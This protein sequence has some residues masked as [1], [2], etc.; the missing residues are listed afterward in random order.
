MTR[1]CSIEYDER[2]FWHVNIWDAADWSEVP[3]GTPV[4]AFATTQ[5]GA[6]V[7]DAIALARRKFSPS[8]ICVWDTCVECSGEGEDADGSPCC[9]CD[10]EG[11]RCEDIGDGTALSETQE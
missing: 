7:D 3:D 6:T 8:T 2:G 1:L 5:D 11:F 9:E 10:G 4:D